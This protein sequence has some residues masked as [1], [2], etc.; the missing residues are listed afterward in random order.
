MFLPSL[1][2]VNPVDLLSTVVT[3]QT[4]QTPWPL[5]R[6]QTLPTERPPLLG[7]I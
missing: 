3:K 6:K 7:E 5:V 4:K 1:A 2:S